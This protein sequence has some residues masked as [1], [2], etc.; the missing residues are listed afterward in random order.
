MSLQRQPT[1]TVKRCFL[2]KFNNFNFKVQIRSKELPGIREPILSRDIASPVVDTF[3]KNVFPDEKVLKKET[4]KTAFFTTTKSVEIETLAPTTTTI[5]PSTT[6]A[7][8]TDKLLKS[9]S[10]IKFPRLTNMTSNCLVDLMLIIGI[11]PSN[12][13]FKNTLCR[14][15]RV[16]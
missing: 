4:Y 13:F 14:R 12:I 6:K 10:I 5:N 9:T 1:M 15:F 3:N 8:K 2:L 11:S 7:P 16:C